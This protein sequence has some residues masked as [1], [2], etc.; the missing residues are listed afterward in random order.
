[1]FK[2]RSEELFQAKSSTQNH[3]LFQWK[4]LNGHFYKTQ[5]LNTDIYTKT[6]SQGKGLFRKEPLQ[7]NE[8]KTYFY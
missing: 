6:F 1:M 7:R 3:S 5:T 4:S 8:P 2:I